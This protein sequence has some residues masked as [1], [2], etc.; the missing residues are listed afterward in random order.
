MKF[1]AVLIPDIGKSI[2]TRRWKTAMDASSHARAECKLLFRRDAQVSEIEIVIL[3]ANETIQS[4][5]KR[6][7]T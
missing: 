2:H 3:E 1:S 6:R 4:E 5:K 7:P